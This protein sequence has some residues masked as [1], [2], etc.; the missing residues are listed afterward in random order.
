MLKNHKHLKATWGKKPTNIAIL[1]DKY[2]AKPVS[3]MQ[4]NIS[5]T[6]INYMKAI[7]LTRTFSPLGWHLLEAPIKAYFSE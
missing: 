1:K 6:Q 4:S 7:D 5:T 3:G 2:F